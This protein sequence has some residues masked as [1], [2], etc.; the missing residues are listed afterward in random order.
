[1]YM[2]GQII[3]QIVLIALNA[4]FACTEVA[5][6]STSDVRLEKLAAFLERKLAAQVWP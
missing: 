3:L 5:V 1:M 6:I 2:I 4:L